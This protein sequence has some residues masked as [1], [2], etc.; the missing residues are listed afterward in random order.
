MLKYRPYRCPDCR[1][2][3]EI[4]TSDEGP[5]MDY[6][7]HCSTRVPREFDCI[8]SWIELEVALH[9]DVIERSPLFMGMSTWEIKRVLMVGDIR[10]IPAEQ[11]I[12]EQGKTDRFTYVLLSGG[13]RV[14]I[15]N[16]SG[17]SVESAKIGAGDVFGEVASI[18]GI[19]RTADV[20]TDVESEVF[21]IDSYALE[22]IG[23]YYPR[24]AYRMCRNSARVLGLRFRGVN[25]ELAEWKELGD[26]RRTF[27]E[28]GA[29]SLA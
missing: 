7:D 6:C 2:E 16:T 18:L 4:L 17:A 20:V 27:A 3:K 23:R 9:Q 8:E 29:S 13:A 5:V 24:I 12:V 10:K 21:A 25:A 26:V 22:R 15:T 19:A 28:P 11:T 1:S 14:M